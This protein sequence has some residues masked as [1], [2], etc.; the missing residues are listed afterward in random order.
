MSQARPPR[1]LR[2]RKSHLD[3]G[4]RPLYPILSDRSSPTHLIPTESADSGTVLDLL[5]SGTQIHDPHYRNRPASLASISAFISSTTSDQ[6]CGS[7]Y[8]SNS[9]KTSG[10]GNLILSLARAWSNVS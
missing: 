3:Q 10:T 1:Y 4:S 2:E 9:F 5:S 7:T 6:V 8:I